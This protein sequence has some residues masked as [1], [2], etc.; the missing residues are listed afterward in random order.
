MNRE[1]AEL[2]RRYAAGYEI[3]AFVEHDPSQFMHRPDCAGGDAG[4]E[5]A[6]FLASC[7][8]FGS[9]DQFVPKIDR[10]YRLAGGDVDSWVR[11]GAFRRDVP[12]DPG[13]CYYRFVT[14]ANLRAFL[15]AYRRVMDAYGTLG[16]CVK[17]NG[18]G[19]G[20]GAVKAICAAF[21]GSGAGCLVPADAKSA[22]KRVCMFLRWMVRTGSP[23][24]LGLWS[25]FIDRRT[26][27]VPLDTHVLQEA[28]RLGLMAGRQSSMSAA[29]RLTAALAEIFPDDPLKGDIALFGHGLATQG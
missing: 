5:A 19:T 23:V 11:T 14:C 12:G 25:G 6:A 10:L 17:A 28:C 27:I 3:A 18:D 7:F 16:G 8:S 4:R 15:E 24:D 9:I 29:R 13:R 26:L 22:C 2:L 20:L 21:S 1:T